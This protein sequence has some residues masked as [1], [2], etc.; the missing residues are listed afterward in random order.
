MRKCREEKGEN[1]ERVAGSVE[2]RKGKMNKRKCVLGKYGW[3]SYLLE[4]V[5]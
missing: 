1:E 3:C 2:K 5:P 4:V